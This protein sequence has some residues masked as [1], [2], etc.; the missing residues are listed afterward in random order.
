MER[1]SFPVRRISSTM[2]IH[3][4]HHPKFKSLWLT[5]AFTGSNHQDG[6]ALYVAVLHVAQGTIRIRQS[7][8]RRA[9]LDV[10]LG[11][12]G[13]ER[14]GVLASIG[15]FT[16]LPSFLGKMAAGVEGWDHPGRNAREGERP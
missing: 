10:G 16:T 14:A 5:L 4:A 9:R 15:G 11:G 8:S 7:V 12:L 2:A 1:S 3:G 6:C 13:E